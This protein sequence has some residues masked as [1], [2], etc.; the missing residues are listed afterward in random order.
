MTATG[1]GVAL[2]ARGIV[3]PWGTGTAAFRDGLAARRP[4]VAPLGGLDAGGQRAAVVPD[5]DAAAVLPRSRGLREFDRTA[6]LLAGAT[7]LALHDAAGAVAGEEEVGIVVGSTYGTI[8]SIIHFDMDAISEGPTYVSPL[9]FPN[10]VLNAPAGRV[11]A[12]FG[13]RGVN[14]T[15]STGETSGLDALVYAAEWLAAGRAPCLLAGS[16]FGV[17]PSLAEPFPDV[18]GEGAAVFLLE[19]AARAAGR[20]AAP[21]ARVAG[22]ATTF[23][24]RGSDGASLATAAATAALA[25]AGVAA[26]E[27][28]LVVAGGRSPAAHPGLEDV[29]LGRLLEDASCPVWS[30]V[31]ALGDCLDASGAFGVAA[32]LEALAGGAA[33]VLVCAFSRAGNAAFVVLAGAAS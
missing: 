24:P 6:L 20:G 31:P 12:L 29:V 8:S 25:D 30:L 16:G 22:F 10:T 17:S 33:T 21:Y 27:L 32:A 1:G 7:A 26:A 2:T 15:L 18:L 9:A 11:A 14:A 28:G 3:S 23:V 4:A 19:P 13:M 5:F